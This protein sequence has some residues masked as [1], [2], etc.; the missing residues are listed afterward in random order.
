MILITFSGVAVS[1]DVMKIVVALEQSVML[2]HP[3]ILFTNVGS[4][5][6]G[7]HFT[8]VIR[9]NHVPEVMEQ[10][11]DHGFFIGPVR[12]SPGCALEAVGITVNLVTKFIP[13]HCFQ[14]FQQSVRHA[15]AAFFV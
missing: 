4:Q 14:K 6:R 10:G 1:P 11:T 12:F 7:N 9:S 2:Q 15:I 3:V 8:V 13:L 5:D